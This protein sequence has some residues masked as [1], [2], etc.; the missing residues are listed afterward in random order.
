MRPYYERAGV[1]I[2]CSKNLDAMA[3]LADCSI[4]ATVTDPPYELGFMGRKWDS[5][6]IAYDPAMWAE[7]L[8]VLKPGAHLLAFGGTRTY[9]RM[10]CAIE[11]AGFEIRDCLMWCYGSG[12][13]KSL[14]ISKVIDREAGA[15]RQVI[16]RRAQSG[17]KFKLTQGLIDNGGFNDPERTTF[18]V[19]VPATDLAR[20]WDGW[21]TAL[22]PAVEPIV[23]ARKPIV[24]TVAANVCE[25]G[26]GAINVD[27]CRIGAEHIATHG[28]GIN[29]G[30]RKYGGG[31]GIPAIQPGANPHTGRWPANLLLSHHPDCECIGEKRVKGHPQGHKGDGRNR[32]SGFAMQP[33]VPDY[34]DADGCETVQDWHCHPDC[35]VRL[36]DEQSG[37]RK[38]GGA[39]KGTEPSRTGQNG[40]YGIYERVQ[41][42]PLGDTGGASRFFYVAKAS[43]SDRGR[44][45]DHPTVKPI[46]LMCYLCRLIT[47]PGGLVLDPFMGSGSTL[48][49]AIWEG[50]RVIG[51]DEDEHACQIAVPR[52]AQDVLPLLSTATGQEGG[53]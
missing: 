29:H 5:T 36:L 18:D 13:P 49:G 25:W 47:P 39:V 30:Q 6:G 27:G 35:P 43:R 9:H 23:L 21:G 37:E 2:Y 16:E 3:T 51:V 14:D 46:N 40:I 22:K 17:V 45:N 34:T 41:N 32:Q 20:Q 1:S 7:V 48:A 4:D 50:F 8:R 42:H 24:G 53:G 28:G 44:G 15:E 19:T 31:N 10:A 38:A 52:L 33:G 11:D 12:F 26:T